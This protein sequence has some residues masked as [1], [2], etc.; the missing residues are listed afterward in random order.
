MKPRH[1]AVLIWVDTDGG[2]ESYP[3]WL[4]QPRGFVKRDEELLR[5]VLPLYNFDVCQETVTKTDELRGLL[6]QREY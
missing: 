5:D 3:S 4:R 1:L 2:Q 6:N